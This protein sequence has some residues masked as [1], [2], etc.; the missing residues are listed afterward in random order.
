M[1]CGVNRGVSVELRAREDVYSSPLVR[2]QGLVYIKRVSNRG[3][4]KP[5]SPILSVGQFFQN[6]VKR[7]RKCFRRSCPL[8]QVRVSSHSF[9]KAAENCKTVEATGGKI[10]LLCFLEN[11]IEVSR[12]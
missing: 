10:L 5:P 11:R 12:V 2:F 8:C 7:T 9:E 4:F 1:E 6:D 3:N